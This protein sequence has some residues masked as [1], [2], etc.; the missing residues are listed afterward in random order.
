MLTLLKSLKLICMLFYLMD[1][2]HTHMLMADIAECSV[3]LNVLRM[4]NTSGCQGCAQWEN[5]TM[6]TEMVG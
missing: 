2:L 6:R 3:A 5:T 4:F 1:I